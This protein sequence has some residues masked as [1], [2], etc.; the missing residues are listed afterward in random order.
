MKRLKK[1]IVINLLILVVLLSIRYYKNSKK[2]A[3]TPNND[4]IPIAADIIKKDT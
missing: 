2:V 1:H 4:C 3:Y